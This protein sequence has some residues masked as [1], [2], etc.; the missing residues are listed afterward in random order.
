MAIY[1]HPL[2]AAVRGCSPVLASGAKSPAGGPAR[3]RDLKVEACGN[4]MKFD[5]VRAYP[6]L[7]AIL[8]AFRRCDRA[9]AP[10]LRLKNMPTSPGNAGGEN[11]AA[12]TSHL[13][14]ARPDGTAPFAV[15]ASQLFEMPRGAANPG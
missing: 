9:A 12:T 8:P 7:Q 10:A 1:R 6:V 14:V 3:V 2:A 13:H 15:A 5:K 11:R 4:P